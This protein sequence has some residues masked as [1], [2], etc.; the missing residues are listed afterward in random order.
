MHARR[1]CRNAGRRKPRA[2][3]TILEILAVLLILSILFGFLL[4]AITTLR[5]SAELKR[6][7]TDV[8]AI[9][10]AVKEY[11]GLFGVWP[12]QQQGKKDRLYAAAAG[13]DCPTNVIAALIDNPRGLRLLAVPGGNPTNAWYL[14]PWN[15]PYMIVMDENGDG[16]L[17]DTI[18]S[19]SEVSAPNETA[20]ALTVAPDGKWIKSWEL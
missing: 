9:A 12:G 16:R 8:V 2:A 17:G 10:Q 4:S 5:R 19:H 14:D 13:A 18:P 3:F 7:R 15:R 11:R 6:A 20:G 1:R